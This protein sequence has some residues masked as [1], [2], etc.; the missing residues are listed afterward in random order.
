MALHLDT[1]KGVTVRFAANPDEPRLRIAPSVV[2]DVIVRGLLTGAGAALVLLTREHVGIISVTAVGIL[3]L[4][5]ALVEW[6][7]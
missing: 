4:G 5:A 3:A 2:A 1:P 7:H 6:N